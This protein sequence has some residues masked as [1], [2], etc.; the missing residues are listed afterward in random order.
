MCVGAAVAAPFFMNAA[1][2]WQAGSVWCRGRAWVVACPLEGI[3]RKADLHGIDNAIHCHLEA[4]VIAS[5]DESSVSYC[6]IL[7]TCALL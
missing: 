6:Y 4:V 2:E 3:A 7:M 1:T 5:I